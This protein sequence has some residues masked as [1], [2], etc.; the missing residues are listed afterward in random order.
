MLDIDE[1]GY[2]NLMDDS[3]ECRADLKAGDDKLAEEIQAKFDKDEDVL[4][5]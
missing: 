5:S 3:G 2:L 1:E 4:V